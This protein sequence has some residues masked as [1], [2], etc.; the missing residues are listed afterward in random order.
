[1]KLA[2]LF[3]LTVALAGTASAQTV[4]ITTGFVDV[5]GAS[6]PV[7]LVGDRGFTY[8]SGFTF[9]NNLLG[10][11]NCNGDPGH[12]V[13]GSTLN[14]LSVTGDENGR[15]TLD[16]VTYKTGEFEPG[17]VRL[18]FTGSLTLPSSPP[19][20][21]ILTTPF[22]LQGSFSNGAGVS[23]SL[24]GHGT[25]E[26]YAGSPNGP[27]P[28]SWRVGRVVFKFSPDFPGDAVTLDVGNVGVP[29]TVNLSP[30]GHYRVTASGSDIWGN[31]DSFWFY[32]R[33]WSYPTISS[34]M[35]VRVDSLGNTSPFAKA[36]L[37][38]RGGALPD[39]PFVILDAKPD[40]GLEFMT[41]STVGGD[42]TY[43]AGASMAF[44]V[45]LRL[46]SLN[47]TVTAFASSDGSS[48]Q[49]IGSVQSDCCGLAGLAVTSHDNSTATEANFDSLV[50]GLPSPWQDNDFG[51]TG[52]AGSAR[53]ENNGFVVEGAGS[54][55]WGT[56][57]SF[58]FLYQYGATNGSIVARI[59]SESGTN[60]F[61][62]AGPM[63]RNA[64][65]Y[66]VA[67]SESA[68]DVILDIK[69]DGGL[70]FMSRSQAGGETTYLGGG[71]SHAFPIW[72]KLVRSGDTI[73]GYFSDD[74]SSWS[75]V[76]STAV[77]IQVPWFGLAVTSHDPSQSNSAVFD[78]VQ[79]TSDTA[80]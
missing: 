61:A 16:G 31:A 26:V 45:W 41:R 43:I 68:P 75:P 52:L 34:D 39:A 69:P 54:D 27:Y 9:G 36:G 10:P 23:V 42:T 2:F 49:T 64:V 19:P 30:D 8:S 4:N 32:G 13:S 59:A 55:I 71:G 40:G 53:F 28:N 80:P 17:T 62:K 51:T 14:L 7:Y 74:G 1:M 15:A 29:S 58:N 12:C 72:L 60:T 22:T 33:E 46:Q 63:I 24:A 56:A 20:S 79:V 35:S 48:W 6:G 57:D 38:L 18:E 73:T 25:A 77:T 44:P 76:A 3:A 37:M 47:G 21:G 67:G 66:F 78:N 11:S 50:V 5:S 65:S 70:E